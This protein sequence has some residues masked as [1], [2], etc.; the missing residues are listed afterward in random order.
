MTPAE[1][2]GAIDGSM[3][4]L[5]AYAQRAWHDEL[6]IAGTRDA[7]RELHTLIG[8]ALTS[9][10][11]A[12]A[13]FFAADGEGY[14]AHVVVL[15]VERAHALPVPYT[16]PIAAPPP[17]DLTLLLAKPSTFDASPGETP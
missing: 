3:N 9:N 13:E 14:V 5:H 6:T 2:P 1:H 10:D 4:V 11:R 8:Q 17:F 16:D 12:S 15:P 7:L